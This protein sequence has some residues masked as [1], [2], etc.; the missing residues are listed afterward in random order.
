[1]PVLTTVYTSVPDS[2]EVYSNL[3]IYKIYCYLL[4]IEI[5]L[6]SHFAL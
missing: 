6:F 1:M 3:M 4:T 5:W 2:V